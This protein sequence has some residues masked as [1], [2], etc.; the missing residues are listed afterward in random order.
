[1]TFVKNAM[2]SYWSLT[3]C[4]LLLV[5]VVIWFQVSHNAGEAGPPDQSELISLDR[6]LRPLS[7]IQAER[8]GDEKARPIPATFYTSLEGHIGEVLKER[9]KQGNKLEL[10]Y[11]D[12]DEAALSTLRDSFTLHIDMSENPTDG[13]V[14]EVIAREYI[15][16]LLLSERM[17]E[18]MPDKKTQET[19]RDQLDHLR[20]ELN[21]IFMERLSSP[22]AVEIDMGISDCMGRFYEGLTS[23]RT[24]RA[25]LALPEAQL[26]EIVK[27]WEKDYD[28]FAAQFGV[29]RQRRAS[30]GSSASAPQHPGMPD[31]VLTALF[32]SL[33]LRS[34]SAIYREQLADRLPERDEKISALLERIRSRQQQSN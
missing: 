30:V 10:L 21:R 25:K 15:H 1:M 13:L 8:L 9:V 31:R 18:V 24:Y 7:R 23:P 6:A 17:S 26:A 32:S 11:K 33:F 27:R 14:A 29:D 19:I 28:K 5:A 20:R 22:N 34:L 12:A 2:R 16:Y 3:L 4:G